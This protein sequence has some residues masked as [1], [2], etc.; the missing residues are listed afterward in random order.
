MA[1]SVRVRVPLIMRQLVA[2]GGHDAFDRLGRIAVPTLLVHGTEDAMLPAANSR[3][4]VSQIPD[5]RLVELEGVGHLFWWEQP[6]RSAELVRDHVRA[7][8]ATG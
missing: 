1:L 8:A 3:V 7:A 6:Q 5:A 4:M 2:S